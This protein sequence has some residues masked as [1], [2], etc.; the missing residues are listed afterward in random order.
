[1]RVMPVPR[2]RPGCLW[3]A[4]GD[5]HSSVRAPVS[6]AS[7]LGGGDGDLPYSAPSPRRSEPSPAV[8]QRRGISVPKRVWLRSDRRGGRKNEVRS[9]LGYGIQ[10]GGGLFFSVDEHDC[11]NHLGDQGWAVE[12][13]PATLP[14]W[15]SWNTMVRQ[16]IRLPLPLV[17][18]VRGSTLVNV[19]SIGLVVR[20]CTQCSAGKS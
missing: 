17:L 18:S 16:A 8:F 7:M 1:M 13:S 6:A 5:P 2:P 19:D 15:A 11:G 3:L 20:M 4:C 14:L 12:R 9:N 10:S